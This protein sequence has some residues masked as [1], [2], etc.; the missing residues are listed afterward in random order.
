[1]S[2]DKG[3]DTPPLHASAIALGHKG[4]LFTGAS[5]SGKSAMALELVALGAELVADDMVRIVAGD[6]GWPML[7]ATT[8]LRGV[9]EA[10]GLGLITVPHRARAPLSLIVEMDRTETAR[11]PD[12]VTRD[13]LGQPV[14][15]IARVDT[16]HFPAFLFAYLK[17]GRVAVSPGD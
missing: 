12:Q 17:G 15:V 11:L 4:V 3:K 13:I 14:P 16:P 10:R 8:R 7:S 5:G 6:E 9:I 1:M 2:A